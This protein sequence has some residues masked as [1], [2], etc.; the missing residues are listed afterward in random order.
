MSVNSGVPVDMYGFS[1]TQNDEQRQLIAKDHLGTAIFKRCV[2]HEQL[3][4][5][6]RCLRYGLKG[7]SAAFST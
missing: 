6:T 7:T 2:I 4:D 5:Q 1:P 3:V